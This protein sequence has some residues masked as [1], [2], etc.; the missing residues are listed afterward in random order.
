MASGHDRGG[1]PG[2]EVA[3]EVGMRGEGRSTSARAEMREA[4]DVC[5]ATDPMAAAFLFVDPSID[6]RSYID[7]ARAV[8]MT[9]MP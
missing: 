1:G 8:P 2:K 5:I 7:S 9:G 6:W 3:V 4:G